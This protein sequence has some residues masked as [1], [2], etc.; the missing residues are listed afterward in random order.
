MEKQKILQ[1][2]GSL[3][4]AIKT[5]NSRGL[6]L[7]W[8]SGIGKYAEYY[9]ANKL[10][11]RHSVDLPSSPEDRYKW[12][13]R[14]KDIP[15]DIYLRDSSEWIEVKSGHYN[16]D[17]ASAS[18]RDGSQI[19]DKKFKFCFFLTFGKEQSEPEEIFVFKRKELEGI[20]PRLAWA[21]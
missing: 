6:F 15:A 10:A 17:F 2:T 7:D 19:R 13:E 9:V 1:V 5:L 18:F 20:K 16:G 21:K 14:K 4:K 8:Q 11:K 3:K 12:K